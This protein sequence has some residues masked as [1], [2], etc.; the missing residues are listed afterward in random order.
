[1]S[2]LRFLFEKRTKIVCTLGPST[3][4]LDILERLVRAGMNVARL[5]FS[6]GDYPDHLRLMESVR[7]VCLSMGGVPVA[8]LQ[9]LQ[10]PRIR[11]GAL[12][13]PREVSVGTEVVLTTNLQEPSK[14]KIGVSYPN[15]HEDVKPDHRLLI[16]D[17]T[18]VL[19]VLRVEERDIICEVEVGGTIESHK[20]LNVPGANLRVS[21]ITEKDIEDL[22]FGIEHGVDYV[23]LS[24]VRTVEDITNLRQLIDTLVAE[25][26]E[27]A[28]AP[29]ILAKIECRPAVL[30]LPDLVRVSD[31]IMVARGDLGIEIPPEEVP[32]V[33][34]DAIRL[35]LAYHTP[36]IV[37]TQMLDSMIVNPRPTRAEVSDV[38][39]AVMDHA[40]A[41]MLSGE[42]SVGKYPVEAV[43]VMARAANT[44][45]RSPYDDLELAEE[46]AKGDGSATCGA[47]ARSAVELVRRTNAVALLAATTT[48]EVARLLAH[49]RVE[50]PVVIFTNSPV[51]FRQLSLVWGIIPFLMETDLHEALLRH[52]PI[53]HQAGIV[54]EGDRIVI[55]NSRH[56]ARVD[57]IDRVTVRE[58]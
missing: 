30:A 31:G 42:T 7:S 41:V 57:D 12:S 33:Q 48:G 34:K 32:I 8:I 23:A 2:D 11:I 9:D 51:V 24:F 13:S 25:R 10:G 35:C 21:T 3:S 40:D 28:F 15:L 26:G 1:M 49:F 20:G 58:V 47:T 14:E 5:N 39:H 16:A 43:S 6:H 19:R 50:V 36:C 27:G 52:I 54:A 37:A 45:E 22:R 29:R 4:A 38:S 46:P 17:G 18:I 44:A 53:L 56:G 55:V